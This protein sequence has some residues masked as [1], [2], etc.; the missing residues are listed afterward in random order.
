MDIPEA[1]LCSLPGT[2]ASAGL[3]HFQ[4][5]LQPLNEAETPCRH[6]LPHSRHPRVP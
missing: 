3:C 2:L 1:T 6:A 5:K 4:T